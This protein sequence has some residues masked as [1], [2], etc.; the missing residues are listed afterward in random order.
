MGSS[1]MMVIIINYCIIIINA[2]Y[3]YYKYIIM[4]GIIIVFVIKTSCRNAT[5]K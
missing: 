2:Y 1:I 5:R 4:H 3:K